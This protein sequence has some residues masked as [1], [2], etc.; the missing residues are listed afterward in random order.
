MITI[1]FALLSH[2]TCSI[3]EDMGVTCE[4]EQ[5]SVRVCDN[6]EV[7]VNKC[8]GTCQ[9]FCRII[10]TKPWYRATCAC[11]KSQTSTYKKVSC[12]DGSVKQIFSAVSC[13]C[14][15]CNGAQEKNIYVD[16]IKMYATYRRPFLEGINNKYYISIFSTRLSRKLCNFLQQQIGKCILYLSRELDFQ[17]VA[18]T[19]GDFNL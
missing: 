8:R 6:Q 7:K 10:M 15:M 19:L 17:C 12:N 14:Q 9:S 2:V 1:A 3:F 4:L 18:K 16:W 11:C 5:E 13:Q